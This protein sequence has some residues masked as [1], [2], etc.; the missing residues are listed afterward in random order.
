M[1][2]VL[3]TAEMGAAAGSSSSTAKPSGPSSATPVRKREPASTTKPATA[4]PAV[5]TGASPSELRAESVV[6]TTTAAE[7]EQRLGRAARAPEAVFEVP[8]TE[9]RL[10]IASLAVAITSGDVV[11]SLVPDPD[12]GTIRI[13][14]RPSLV[15]RNA[16]R[17][18]RLR[19]SVDT[20]ILAEQLETWI[21]Q[22]IRGTEP[23]SLDAIFGPSATFTSTLAEGAARPR[24]L[25]LVSEIRAGRLE[26]Q[27]LSV[28][29][30]AIRLAAEL[31]PDAPAA[32]PGR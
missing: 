15:G 9:W 1:V 19:I 26:P 18:E 31:K 17:A 12:V 20:P 30:A 29:G 8:G 14:G 23:R 32:A 28:E 10:R 21:G 11:I 6:A 3:V 16:W 7:L 22:Q 25:P 2:A 13:R 24:V 27:S 5:R 4:K